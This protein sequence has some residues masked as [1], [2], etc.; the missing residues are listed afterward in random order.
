MVGMDQLAARL[1][2]SY[3]TF[4]PEEIEFSESTSPHGLFVANY[5]LGTAAA[6]I[7]E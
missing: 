4:V 6:V 2:S 3:M 5:L 7:M 1:I